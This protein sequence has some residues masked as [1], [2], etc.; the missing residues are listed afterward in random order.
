VSVVDQ[1]GFLLPVGLQEDAVDVVDVDG[2]VGAADGFDQTAD[3]EVAGQAQDAVGGGGRSGRWRAAL[4]VLCPSPA[5]VEFALMKS[6][7]SSALSAW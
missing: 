2:P 6:R 5:A 1:V 3:A 7:R 4:K